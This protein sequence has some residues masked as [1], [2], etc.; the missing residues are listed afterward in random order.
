MTR[1]EVKALLSN[2]SGEKWLMASLMYG[3]R[4]RF[5]EC[6]RLRVQDIDFSL[7]E[8]LVRD[9]KNAKDRILCF[10]NH[11]ELRFKTSMCVPTK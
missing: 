8:I 9:G 10:L 3:A 7:N 6:L 4:L 5:L 11:S 1:D 2:L